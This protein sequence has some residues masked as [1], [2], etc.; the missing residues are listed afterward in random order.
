[1]PSRATCVAT[2]LRI[3]STPSSPSEHVKFDMKAMC[4]RS[5]SADVVVGPSLKDNEDTES[6][7][8]TA[9]A[10]SEDTYGEISALL[11]S[12][13]E[14]SLRAVSNRVVA[15]ANRSKEENNGDTLARIISLVFE[16]ATD[17]AT[18]SELYAKLCRSTMDCINLD[19]RDYHM[20]D[21]EGNLITGPQL[22]CRY[23]LNHCQEEFERGLDGGG[24]SS[25]E[26]QRNKDQQYL[27]FIKFLGELF[28][29]KMFAQRT[30]CECLKTLLSNVDSTGDPDL[31]IECLGALLT[32]IGGLLDSSKARAHMDVYFSH[33][34]ELSRSP[35]VTPLNQLKLQSLINL[36][37]EGWNPSPEAH[38]MT[39]DDDGIGGHVLGDLNI[40]SAN[41]NQQPSP[42]NSS[43]V[44]LRSTS[45]P[46]TELV[47]VPLPIDEPPPAP[48]MSESEALARAE[49]TSAE[50]FSVRDVVAAK[51]YFIELPPGHHHLLVGTLVDTA[52]SSEA[53]ACLVAELFDSAASGNLC[54]PAAFE[55][56]FV[57]TTKS[58]ADIVEDVPDAF[59]SYVR[60]F[61]GAHLD[62]DVE[63]WTRIVSMSTE[64]DELMPL[65][66]GTAVSTFPVKR[67]PLSPSAPRVLEPATNMVPNPP[68]K[69]NGVMDDKSP[70]PMSPRT[71]HT[72]RQSSDDDDLYAEFSESPTIPSSHITPAPTA[73]QRRINAQEARNQH[74]STQ[75]P[76][77]TDLH[78][79]ALP[80]TVTP[81]L[82]DHN[83]LRLVHLR[84]PRN[85]A[86]EHIE[87]TVALLFG[88]P[89]DIDSALSVFA[90][91]P[92]RHHSRFVD[93][94]VSF[95][96]ESTRAD[97]QLVAYFFYCAAVKG[98]CS[99][100]A[101][102]GGF[103]LTAAALED[104]AAE[105]PD[106]V[107]LFATMAKGAG[108]HRDRE[109]RT[110]FFG[111]LERLGYGP[112]L[113]SLSSASVG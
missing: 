9:Q 19:V 51:R 25:A 100:A 70:E 63:C 56:G 30:I 18:K 101:F 12:L 43:P 61:K 86:N 67:L 49:E 4:Q 104:V 6:P 2:A 20:K 42:T 31:Y 3:S 55:A 59:T 16:K 81:P 29:V 13:S 108:L 36:R 64:S 77:A 78:I 84:M 57:S 96:I 107:L 85:E 41:K 62:A 15:W 65:L 97:A 54:S 68:A 112:D 111:R 14:V 50:F 110:R 34:Q 40:P 88:G 33:I 91:I 106:V 79:P 105:S 46:M 38:G 89:H 27:G 73:I 60:M 74:I 44:M 52:I 17:N 53:D 103:A 58:L 80:R 82:P 45:A 39:V 69:V 87:Q 113:A 11:S 5:S 21:G 98:L 7:L 1:M 72:S 48:F 99:A 95:A 102:E 24:D 92:P 10:S 26:V 37:Q 94:L 76:R 22:F 8:A 32:T 66:F 83:N 90:A 28:K 35:A 109:W 75:V 71:V 93:R 23:L 47:D